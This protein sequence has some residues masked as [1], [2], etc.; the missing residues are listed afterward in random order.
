MT[1]IKERL[2][3]SAIVRNRFARAIEGRHAFTPATPANRTNALKSVLT[4]IS[5][6]AVLLLISARA[7]SAIDFSGAWASDPRLCGKL[8]QKTGHTISISG[9]DPVGSNG[10]VIDHDTL[11]TQDGATCK[12]KTRKQDGDVI[13]FTAVCTTSIMIS[14]IAFA[15]KSVDE[16]HIAV[17]FPGMS[18]LETAF[19]RCQEFK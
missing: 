18:D 7:A 14:N 19:Y 3:R 13:R 16:N 11:R 17:E 15:L 5:S 10:F 8:F 4:L 9:A 6:V 12:I 1:C 2:E